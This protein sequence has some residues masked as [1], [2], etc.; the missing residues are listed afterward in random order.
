[1]AKTVKELQN[2]HDGL[3]RRRE[4]LLPEITRVSEDLAKA[5]GLVLSE[6]DAFARAR[7]LSLR[8]SELAKERDA[9]TGQIERVEEPVGTIATIIA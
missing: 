5:R 1:M 6:V 7:A 2:E 9:L 4:I 8:L 3:V